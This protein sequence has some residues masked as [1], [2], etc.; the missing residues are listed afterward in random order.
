M[1]R[2]QP[3]DQRVRRQLRRLARLHTADARVQA[4]LNFIFEAHRHAGE[5]DHGQQQR[6]H[7]ADDGMD[8]Q[9]RGLDRGLVMTGRNMRKEASRSV[10]VKRY[11]DPPSRD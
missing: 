2:L 7:E 8:L 11:Q 3:R 1:V 5:R 6:D 4:G 9:Q 10:N